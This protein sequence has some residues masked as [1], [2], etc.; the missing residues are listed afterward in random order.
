MY[1]CVS[2]GAQ[3]KVSKAFC[4]HICRLLTKHCSNKA[5]NK[6]SHVCRQIYLKGSMDTSLDIDHMVSR[7][8]PKEQNEMFQ[9]L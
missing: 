6:A 3:A 1:G 5:R 8:S 9:A 2:K 7:G 4:I